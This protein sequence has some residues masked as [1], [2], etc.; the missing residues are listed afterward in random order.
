M[1]HATFWFTRPF[2]DWIGQRSLTLHWEGR[3]T[4]REVFQRL[5][6]DHPAFRANVPLPSLEQEA[7]D[8]LAAV[9][10]DGNL[11]S[12]GSEIRDGATV[13]V[14][15]PLTGGSSSGIPL[16]LRPGRPPVCPAGATVAASP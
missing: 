15:L 12:L 16:E 6:A 5:A 7:V 2:R 9:I 8:M 4:V 13:D 10:M 14:L 3:L 1:P 11:L